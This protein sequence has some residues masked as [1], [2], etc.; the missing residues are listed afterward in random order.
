MCTKA[1]TRQELM[2][3][4]FLVALLYFDAL[5][6]LGDWQS[7]DQMNAFGFHFDKSLYLK[8][9]DDI[10]LQTCDI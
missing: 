7:I 4:D 5:V 2:K 8:G 3:S 1:N 6:K 9:F 10:N